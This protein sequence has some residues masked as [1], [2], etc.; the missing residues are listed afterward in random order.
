MPI[1][2]LDRKVRRRVSRG[3]AP[4]RTLF[5]LQ[6]VT[7]PGIGI[8]RLFTRVVLLALASGAAACGGTS[9]SGGDGR[10]GQQGESMAADGAADSGPTMAGD[11]ALIRVN[12]VGPLRL[13]EWRRPV[14]SFVYA[15]SARAGPDS[16]DVIVVRGVGKDTMTLTFRNDTLRE[17]DVLKPG[18]HTREGFGI[19]TPLE[20]LLG[21]GGI[22]HATDSGSVIT[23]PNYCGVQFNAA[24]TPP[25]SP[26]AAV[27][28]VAVLPC[29]AQQRK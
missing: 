5:Y 10:G 29:A 26:A 8:I 9:R 3:A 18:P 12:A 13:M 27:D 28:R 1:R 2:A 22:R 7:T 4:K 20:A 25:V 15:V 19:G 16:A 14:M 17:I 11:H 21:A 23:L 6:E 24:G